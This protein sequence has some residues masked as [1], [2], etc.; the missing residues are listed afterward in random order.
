MK[1]IVAVS[2]GPDSMYLLNYLLQRHNLKNIIV[3][4][5]DYQKRPESKL[6]INLV[7]KFCK[8]NNLNFQ[9]LKVKDKHY[10]KFYSYKGFQNKARAIRYDFFYK[11]AKKYKTNFIYTGHNKDDFLETAIMQYKKSQSLLFYGINEKNII[12][13]FT[14]LRP[15]LG[16]WKSDIEKENKNNKV[17]YSIDS[18]N[19]NL[20]YER[21]Q[22]RID[23]EKK[24][25]P[26]KEKLV[27]FFYELNAKNSNNYDKLSDLY[28]EWKKE[29]ISID[30][31]VKAEQDF[32]KSLLY[33]W[34]R[35][36]CN[37]L[38]L[39]SHKLKNLE[40]FILKKNNE[41]KKF[42]LKNNV[43]VAKKNNY[44]FIEFL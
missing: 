2:G 31:F 27:N 16:L 14:I 40:L 8:K 35:D 30:F 10:K 3:A 36:N 13:S 5:V 18:S 9:L 23:L 17:P 7:K 1:I 38:K 28:N 21:N 41:A 19:L 33:L 24:G 25:F 6:E 44:L 39:S 15:L 34:I 11:L 12:N 22:I 4:S 20:K 32:K 26:Y 37:F 42:E 29:R 43:F